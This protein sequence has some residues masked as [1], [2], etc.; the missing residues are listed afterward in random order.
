MALRRTEEQVGAESLTTPKLV[1]YYALFS[2]YAATYAVPNVITDMD[3]RFDN[4]TMF[5]GW[6]SNNGWTSNTL[7]P[8]P[9]DAIPPFEGIECDGTGLV[10]GV[11]LDSNFL[12]G[13]FPP[14]ITLLA[15]DGSASVM[16]AGNLQEIDLF[17]N[18]FLYN[19][20]TNAWMTNLGSNL[21]KLQVQT[22]IFLLIFLSNFSF[23]FLKSSCTSRVRLSLATF[24]D[25]HRALWS[26]MPRSPLSLED[27]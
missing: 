12:T 15:S 23:V 11:K 9:V 17:S 14:E 22:Y 24:P 7:D 16:G 18:P 8:C 6:I 27:S 10:T 3:P 26:S 13:A 5:P 20:E 1:Q 4:L 25:F 2:I 19:N 21:G